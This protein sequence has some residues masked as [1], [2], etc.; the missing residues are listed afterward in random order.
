MIPDA[1]WYVPVSHLMLSQPSG[2]A[3]MRLVMYILFTAK[4]SAELPSTVMYLVGMFEHVF[5]LTNN[6]FITASDRP[7]FRIPEL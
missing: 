6:K 4:K 7:L 2:F 3:Q 1:V 5:A